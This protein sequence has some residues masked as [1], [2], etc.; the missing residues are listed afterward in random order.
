MFDVHALLQLGRPSSLAVSPEG[1]F[2]AVEVARDHGGRFEHRLWRVAHSGEERPLSTG[3]GQHRKPRFAGSQLLC[4]HEASPGDGAQI[5]AI[6]EDGRAHAWTDEPLGISDYAAG[7][8]ALIALAPRWDGV[9]EEE[10]RRHDKARKDAH[11]SSALRYRDT[12]LRHWNHY[13]GPRPELLLLRGGQTERLFREGPRDYEEASFCLDAKGHRGATTVCAPS[14][15]RIVEHRI[16]IFDF[17]SEIAH[18]MIGQEGF[19]YTHLCL[20]PSGRRLAAQRWG[21]RSEG[22]ERHLVVFDLEAGTEVVLCRDWDRFPEPQSWRNEEQLLAL[23]DDAGRRPLYLLSLTGARLC[24]AEGSHAGVD[25]A[26]A[27][28]DLPGP[29]VTLRSSFL[30]PPQVVL[31]RDQRSDVL[32]DLCKPIVAPKPFAA[33][34]EAKAL[35]QV[36]QEELR[37]DVPGAAPQQCWLLRPETP[38]PHPLLF[39]IHGGPHSQFADAWHWR[40][41]PLPFVE[42]G[43]AVALANPSGSTGEGRECLNA[44][45][46]DWPR[47][48]RE[49]L[50]MVNTLSERPDIDATKMAA[51][52]G[53]Y[54][55]YMVNWIGGQAHPFGALVSHAGLYDLRAFYGTTDHASFF[56]TFMGASPWSEADIDLPSPHRHIEG[57]NTPTLVIHGDKD[58]RVPVTEGIALF[59]ALQAHGVDSE[60]LI[61]PDEHHW[62]T[63]PKNIEHWYTS[64]LAFL[65]AK[66]S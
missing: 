43:Y 11:A 8:D 55:G 37:L 24:L 6:T 51:M 13:L 31:H 28:D 27:T 44:V 49:L 59:E 52:G 35:P 36:H 32:G 17:G 61:Y 64:V 48:Q 16:R 41:N 33:A 63:K 45:W 15:R 40:W 54:G 42:A 19:R 50:A 3:A 2:T 30:E 7:T 47:P 4:L 58:F 5:A 53:S 21:V 66:L 25:Q 1:D 23:V 10:Q 34:P 26:P 14:A 39:W 62:I 20:S 46:G 22:L 57:W 12:P 18:R 56:G 9:P 60:L 65:E 29:L 38:G